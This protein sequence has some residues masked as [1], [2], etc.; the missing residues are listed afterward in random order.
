MITGITMLSTVNAQTITGVGTSGIIPKFTGTNT[1]GN[2]QIQDNATNVGI[3]MAGS[4]KLDVNGHTNITST[5]AYKIGGSNILWH[6]GITSNIYVGVGAGT[7]AGGSDNVFVGNDAGYYNSGSSAMNSYIGS[8]AGMNFTG[9]DNTFIGAYAGYGNGGSGSTGIDNTYIGRAAGYN[10]TTGNDNTFTGWQAGVS[11]TTGAANCVYGHSALGGNAAGSYNCVYGWYAG[12]GTGTPTYSNNS[13]FGTKAGF[14]TT[15]GGNNVFLGYQAG[16]SNT[17]GSTNTFIGYN[18]DNS[19]AATITNSAAIGA[20]TVV[21]VSN[22]MILGNGANV[23]IGLSGDATG[24]TSLLSV[25]GNGFS[26]ITGFFKNT[27]NTT[28]GDAGLR[29][30]VATPNSAGN[31][32]YGS[33]GVVTSGTGYCTGIYGSATNASASAGRAYGVL[34]QAGNGTTGYNYGVYGRITGTNNGAAVFGGNAGDYAVPGQYAGVFDGKIR[35]TNDSPEKPTSGSWTGYSD[36]RLK[37]DIA[38]F[39]DGLSVLRQVN[40]VTYKFNGV[41]NL[42]TEETHIGVIAQDIQPVAPYCVGT[43][44]LVVK[45][46]QS[47]V[48][49]NSIAIPADSAGEAQ[50]IVSPLTY[51]YD[52]LIYVMINSIKQLDSINTALVSKDAMKDATI[53]KMENKINKLDSM[54][55]AYSTA[56]QSTQQSNS[57]LQ[58]A[59]NV[60]DVQLSNKNIVVLDQN[61]PNPFAEQT[62]I[63]YYLPEDV[64]TAQMLFYNSNGLLIK[65]VELTSKGKGQ[66]NVFANDLTKGVYT[67][68]L[69]VDGKIVETKKMVK[70]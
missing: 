21:K 59:N 68:T 43:G 23:G 28:D 67:Y 25:G 52:G 45:Q 70:Q 29:A 66:V 58:T 53:A 48:F 50:A 27:D 62:T 65:T 4:Y 56:T 11:V 55:N 10:T 9:N 16:L 44:K 49:G 15:T 3:G 40:P 19:G 38:P 17:T 12:L 39:K 6:N 69:V 20:N 5:S 24:A 7:A 60:T 63:N 13:I 1:I 18:A 57:N 61:S 22:N 33:E 35:T 46:S 31:H 8:H 51:N 41:G 64:K 54:L 42:S 26:Y 34:G 14:A 36:K 30:E 37:K 47:S 32:A 2:S